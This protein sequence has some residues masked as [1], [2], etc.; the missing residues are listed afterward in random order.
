MDTHCPFYIWLR[1]SVPTL[2]VYPPLD[3]PHM[4]A[5][6]GT[7]PHRT[8]VVLLDKTVSFACVLEDVMMKS[9]HCA[10]TSITL[11]TRGSLKKSNVKPFPNTAA[12]GTQY[13]VEEIKR[14]TFSKHCCTISRTSGNSVPSRMGVRVSDLHGLR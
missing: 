11:R 14:Q 6:R 8:Q 1:Q 5:C 9:A 13:Q 12:Q 4:L 7:R 2:V 3:D 10:V